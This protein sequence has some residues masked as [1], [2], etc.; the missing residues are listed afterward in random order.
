M[1]RRIVGPS[2][3][4]DPARLSQKMFSL[5]AIRAKLSGC[6]IDGMNDEANSAV[7]P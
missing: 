6:V 3:Q 7:G 2:E 4:I 5:S 1:Y